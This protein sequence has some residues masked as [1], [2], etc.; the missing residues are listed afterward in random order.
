MALRQQPAPGPRAGPAARRR[1]AG[2][3]RST[4]PLVSDASDGGGPAPTSAPSEASALVEEARGLLDEGRNAAAAEAAGRAAALFA[5]AG[6]ER[7]AAR[8]QRLVADGLAAADHHE[9]ALAV[10]KRARR[11]FVRLDPGGPDAAGCEAAAATSLRAL[12]HSDEAR[13]ALHR[14]EHGFR[15]AAMPVRAAMCELDRA[16]LHH[17]EGDIDDAV[18][19]LERARATFLDERRPDLAAVGDF[20]LGVALLDGGHADDAIERFLSARDIFASLDEQADEAS[21]D[22]NLGVALH[23]V[24]RSD[25]AR[26]ALRR[27]RTAFRDLGRDRDAEQAEHDLDVIDGLVDPDTAELSVLRDLG[28]VPPE[29]VGLAAQLDPPTDPGLPAVADRETD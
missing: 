8:C 12:G 9:E 22:L 26:L 21:C 14:A 16:V 11:T 6:D 20:D 7:A 17:D 24:G 27:A 15:G 4:V 29:L 23:A 2:V 1:P 13:R 18:A 28:E 5:G 10:L 19:L 25:E 3:R